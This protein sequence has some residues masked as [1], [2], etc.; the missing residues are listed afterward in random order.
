MNAGL[1]A[2]VFL[3]RLDVRHNFRQIRVQRGRTI[4]KALKFV[5][6][7]TFLL[8]GF[9]VMAVT[10]YVFYGNS[11]FSPMVNGLPVLNLAIMA[12]CGLSVIFYLVT[13]QSPPAKVPRDPSGILGED[14]CDLHPPVKKRRSLWQGGLGFIALALLF[15]LT[16]ISFWTNSVSWADAFWPIILTS[17]LAATTGYWLYDTFAAPIINGNHSG[18]SQPALRAAL[19]MKRLAIFTIVASFLLIL[20]AIDPTML[21]VGYRSLGAIVLFSATVATIFSLILIQR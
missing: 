4:V 17:V 7:A 19:A 3:C 16:H 13:Y 15:Y 18:K 8:F 9:V 5:A 20:G 14:L 12:A 6:G 10:D 21:N 1:R 2:G 11:F